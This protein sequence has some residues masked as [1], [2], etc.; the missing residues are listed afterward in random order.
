MTNPYIDKHSV[1]KKFPGKSGWTYVD[2]PEI[3]PDKKAPFGWVRV[4]V[5][6]D[7]YEMRKYKLMPMGNGKLFLPVKA[8]IRKKIKKEAGDTVHILM[9]LDHSNLETPEE[10][11]DCFAHEPKAPFEFYA[12]LQQD[13]QKVYLDW[14]YDAKTEDTKAQRI[15]TMMDKLSKK[16]KF[17]Q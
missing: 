5:S 11:I 10:I 7:G 14:I 2:I 9:E 8:A 4:N 17:F 12:S 13:E 1:L 6:I 15:L 3:K 16:K